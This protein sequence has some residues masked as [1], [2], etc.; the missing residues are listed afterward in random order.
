[1]F[2]TLGAPDLYHYTGNGISPVGGWDLMESTYNHPKH[3]LTFMKF[4]YGNWLTGIPEITSSGTYTLNPTNSLTNTCY[5][6]ASPYTT[7]EYFIVEYRRQ[8]GLF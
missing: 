5:K 8:Q 4:R 3:M 7:N 1:M 2:H 6:I